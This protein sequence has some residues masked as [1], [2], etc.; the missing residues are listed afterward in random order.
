VCPIAAE[1]EAPQPLRELRRSRRLSQ[2]D[3]ADVTGVDQSKIS[4]LE[5][6]ELIPTKLMIGV[7]TKALRCKPEELFD[8]ATLA[9]VI[10][11]QKPDAS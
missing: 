9:V 6:G 2:K 11:R 1:P 3:I 10:S 5:R 4:R 8:R 7:L